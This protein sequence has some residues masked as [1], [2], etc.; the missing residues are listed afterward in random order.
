MRRGEVRGVREE[1]L[2]EVRKGRRGI[3]GREGRFIHV[4]ESGKIEGRESRGRR[5]ENDWGWE[6]ERRV[7]RR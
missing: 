4:R 1:G 3:Y 7:R 5:S 6:S 2:W